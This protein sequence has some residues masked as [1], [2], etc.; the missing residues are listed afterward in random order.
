MLRYVNQ[1]NACFELDRL[2]WQQRH[3]ATFIK[4][5]VKIA[6]KIVTTFERRNLSMNLVVASTLTNTCLCMVE[7]LFI[8]AA[9]HRMAFSSNAQFHLV[10]KTVSRISVALLPPKVI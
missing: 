7:C 9:F 2:I 8:K 3:L 4:N 5:N 1:T 6:F 10:F